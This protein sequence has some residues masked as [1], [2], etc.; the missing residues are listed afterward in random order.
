MKN[1]IQHIVLF[2]INLSPQQRQNTVDWHQLTIRQNFFA[3]IASTPIALE[4][5]DFFEISYVV[6][7]NVICA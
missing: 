3:M 6:L 1:L 2:K 5:M 7:G 4:G